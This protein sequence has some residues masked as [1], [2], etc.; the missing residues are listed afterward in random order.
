M[1]R[2]DEISNRSGNCKYFFL[3]D[4]LRGVTFSADMVF[5]IGPSG[6][7]TVATWAAFIHNFNHPGNIVLF[8]V[9]FLVL[10]KR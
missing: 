9:K 1:A 3:L 10:L 2:P 6:V 5:K 8:V 4:P 7:S